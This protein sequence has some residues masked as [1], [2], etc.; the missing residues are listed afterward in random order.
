MQNFASLWIDTV[1]IVERFSGAEKADDSSE[2]LHMYIP[3]CDTRSGLNDNVTESTVMFPVS[4]LLTW[5]LISVPLGPV[6]VILGEA[7]TPAGLVTVQMMEYMR[8]ATAVPS[9]E[10]VTE[11]LDGGTEE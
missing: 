5:P 6:H 10:V 1:A 4:V 11:I 8:P 3:L 2:T 9:V 7:I